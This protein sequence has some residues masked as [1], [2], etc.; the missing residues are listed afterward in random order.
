M[1][2]RLV[3]PCVA[4]LVLAVACSVIADPPSREVVLL[5]RTYSF[6]PCSREWSP[7]T[8]PAERTVVDVF[9]RGEEGSPPAT[10]AQVA[11]VRA[12]GGTNLYAFNLPI[13]RADLDVDA[14]RELV[15]P[16]ASPLS[17]SWVKTVVHPADR[18]VELIVGLSRDITDADIAAVEALGANVRSRWDFIDAYFVEIDDTAVPQ[19]RGLPGVRY[20]ER[21]GILCAG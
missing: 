21:N 1:S 14:V 2:P 9:F 13:V 20:V 18:T 6:G 3:P 19:V 5:D 8:P 15:G 17:A 11:I 10:S 4:L 16:S 12:A 7:G